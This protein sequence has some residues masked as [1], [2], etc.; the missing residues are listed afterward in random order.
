[1]TGPPVKQDSHGPNTPWGHMSREQKA[2]TMRNLHTLTFMGERTRT[3]HGSPSLSFS[4][5]GQTAN[6][7]LV[8]R[9]AKVMIISTL[10]F[11]QVR[12]KVF[13][14]FFTS[15]HWTVLPNLPSRGHE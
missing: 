10:E 13:D 14:Y 2:N 3:D 4:F 6:Q 12:R 11:H 5:D 1:M 15:L 8:V 9:M 7:Q